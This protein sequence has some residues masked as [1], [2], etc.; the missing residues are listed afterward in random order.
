MNTNKFTGNLGAVLAGPLVAAGIMLGSMVLGDS[1]SASAE[2]TTAGQCTGMTMTDG[3]DPASP[4]AL[5]RAGQ[6]GAAAGPGASD[7]S[8]TVNCQATGHS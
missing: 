3:Q 6:I 2:P 8:M 7:G 4:N 5:T 1:A